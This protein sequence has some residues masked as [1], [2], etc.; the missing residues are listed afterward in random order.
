VATPLALLLAALVLVACT[1]FRLVEAYNPAIERGLLDYYQQS[2]LL[3][4]RLTSDLDG[5]ASPVAKYAPKAA[6][7]AANREI[8]LQQNARLQSLILQTRVAD[9]QGR[10]EGTQAV[11][12][13]ARLKAV[14][15]LMAKLSGLKQAFAQAQRIVKQ[16]GNCTLQILSVLAVNQSLMQGLHQKQ[17]V[18]SKPLIDILHP[19]ITQG[20]EMALRNELIKQSLGAS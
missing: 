8:Y 13:L 16:G 2:E 14:E 5:V 6:R 7:Y 12:L 10:C 1:P 9:P 18:L 11:D 20:V 15:G 17:E 19:T 3:F 4:A